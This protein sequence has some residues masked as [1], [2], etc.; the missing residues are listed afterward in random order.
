[1]TIVSKQMTKP[2]MAA[3]SNKAAMI[4][5]VVRKS[6][7]ASGWRAAPSKAAAPIL[8]SPNPVLVGQCLNLILTG[9]A[10]V[11]RA[12]ITEYLILHK[13]HG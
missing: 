6:P 12:F 2:N 5:M 10:A 9:S 11:Q 8:P 4:I 3:P 1:M 13:A 7:A